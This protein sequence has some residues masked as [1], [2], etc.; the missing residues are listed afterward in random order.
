MRVLI[1]SGSLTG[2]FQEFIALDDDKFP[3]ALT[4]GA[5]GDASGSSV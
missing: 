2:T 4:Q 1:L 5:G 3:P